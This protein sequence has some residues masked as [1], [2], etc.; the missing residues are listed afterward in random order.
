MCVICRGE[1]DEKT[2]EIVYKFQTR[3][4]GTST[5]KSPAG[6]FKD[7]YIPNDLGFVVDTINKYYN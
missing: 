7:M 2:T 6:C 1:Y 5:C 3:S 4:D